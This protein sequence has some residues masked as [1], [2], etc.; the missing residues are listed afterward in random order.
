MIRSHHLDRRA[1]TIAAAGTGDPDDLLD[2]SEVAEWLA[3]SSQ[4]L[5]IG[6]HRGY[7]PKFVRLSPRRCR[8]LRSDVLSW[9][10]ERTHAATREYDTGVVGR[11][12]GS[13]VVAGKVVEPL[14]GV[15]PRK[16][17]FRRR[18]PVPAA[19]E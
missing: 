9:L 16:Y 19:V 11:K 3:V 2:T 10:A 4:F 6:R 1:A 5:E 12:R 17:N 8:Y 18:P 15:G 13:R 7:G 14:A